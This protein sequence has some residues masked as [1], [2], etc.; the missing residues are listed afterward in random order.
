MGVENIPPDSGLNKQFSADNY[1]HF[2]E[3]YKRE[4]KKHIDIN[5]IINKIR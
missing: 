4:E 1:P 3:H 5:E 2:M